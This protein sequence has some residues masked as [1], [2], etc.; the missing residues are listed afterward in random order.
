MSELDP[1]EFSCTVLILCCS[2]T[3]ITCNCHQVLV[4]GT[5]HTYMRL[6][7]YRNTLPR[8]RK[9]EVWR[10]LVRGAAFDDLSY[11]TGW[12]NSAAL[13]IERS[14][15]P[16]ATTVYIL[17]HTRVL[18]E[19][20]VST[21]ETDMLWLLRSMNNSSTTAHLLACWNYSSRTRP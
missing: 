4:R 11:N 14:S 12:H 21:A 20:R 16:I 6:I 10:S 8:W 13:R 3:L 2:C 5:I 15:W 1:I 17:G 9:S 18:Q 7:V 19:K